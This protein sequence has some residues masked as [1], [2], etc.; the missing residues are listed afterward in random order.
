M[1]QAEG[2]R[3]GLSQTEEFRADLLQTEEFIN[4]SLRVAEERTCRGQCSVVA[5]VTA[6][7]RFSLALSSPREVKYFVAEL[8]T[9][10]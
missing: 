4:I 8:A 5:T 2:L 3:A 10:R 1:S 7:T 9:C 6:Y